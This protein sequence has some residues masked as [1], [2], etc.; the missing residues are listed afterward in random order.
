MYEKQEL[1]LQVFREKIQSTLKVII[2]KEHAAL[3]V[4]PMRKYI[5]FAQ[6]SCENLPNGNLKEASRKTD[7]SSLVGIVTSNLKLFFQGIQI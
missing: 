5:K 1:T 6:F 2:R 7:C 3:K 4:S